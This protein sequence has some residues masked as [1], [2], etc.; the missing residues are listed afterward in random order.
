[1]A[2]FRLFWAISQSLDR[3]SKCCKLNQVISTFL[4]R[5]LNAFKL[6]FDREKV[7]KKS[8]KS[9]VGSFLS[10]SLP[11]KCH[12]MRNRKN[13][14]F[15]VKLRLSCK[16]ALKN[17]LFPIVI[18]VLTLK[19]DWKL[20]A[21]GNKQK[22]SESKN[23]KTSFGP[24]AWIEKTKQSKKSIFDANVN[25]KSV[26]RILKLEK[27]PVYKNN[28]V[29]KESKSASPATSCLT[30]LA[31]PSRSIRPRK[32]GN[33]RRNWRPKSSTSAKIAR[34][35]HRSDLWHPKKTKARN[36]VRNPLHRSPLQP[37][38]WRSQTCQ[39]DKTWSPRLEGKVQFSAVPNRLIQPRV[40]V[41]LRKSL[42]QES[43]SQF[44]FLQFQP[45]S[46]RAGGSSS[47]FGGTKPVDTTKKEREIDEKLVTK[48][49][50]LGNADIMIAKLLLLVLLMQL[51]LFFATGG[52]ALKCYVSANYGN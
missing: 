24:F 25:F 36:P 39:H 18:S 15:S 23:N 1:M 43:V 12:C 2:N 28:L 42:L 11:Y 8:W 38:F 13:L 48:V 10:H 35:R 20:L 30:F 34:E 37:S 7:E 49:V 27:K 44:C 21:T 14:F 9:L 5:Y 4:S 3:F 16:V 26:K 46:P 31:V 50:D 19:Q 47:I 51:T 17:G 6:V 41:R 52:S 33:S 29:I 32:S 40:S 22:Q 45:W